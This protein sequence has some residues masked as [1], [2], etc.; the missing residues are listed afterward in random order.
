MMATKRIRTVKTFID[1]NYQIVDKLTLIE[2]AKPVRFFV[3]RT[4]E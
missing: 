2:G 4:P 1:Q 3:R